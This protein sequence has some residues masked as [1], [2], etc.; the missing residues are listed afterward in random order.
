MQKGLNL[1]LRLSYT[2]VLLAKQHSHGPTTEWISIFHISW[3]H[4]SSFNVPVCKQTVSALANTGT[5][6]WLFQQQI[7]EQSTM[8]HLHKGQGQAREHP[9][10][11]LWESIM[12]CCSSS[13]QYQQD[14]WTHGN[15]TLGCHGNWHTYMVTTTIGYMRAHSRRYSTT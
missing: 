5:K 6:E 2:D 7:Q 9:T 12:E 10:W 4:V 1:P 11:F 13:T 3:I 15:L 14:P 8:E